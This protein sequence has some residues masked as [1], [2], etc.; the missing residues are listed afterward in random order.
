MSRFLIAILFGANIT[1][2]VTEMYPYSWFNIFAAAVM[3]VAYT[4]KL[5]GE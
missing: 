5:E 1:L 3:W 2:G 4:W